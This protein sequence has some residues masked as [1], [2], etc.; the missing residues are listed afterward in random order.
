MENKVAPQHSADIME[1]KVESRHLGDIV[2]LVPE[3]FRDNR[4]VLMAT[5]RENAFKALG[6]PSQ[7]PLDLHSRSLK[8]VLRGLHF[9]WDPPVGKLMRVIQGTAFL[10]AVDLRKDSPTL[11]KWFGQVFTAAEKKQL[12][13]PA[14][15]ARG[16]C[17]LTDGV[18]IEYLTTA[19]Y[20]PR[21]ETGI[22]WNDPAIGIR[23]PIADPQLSDR[24]RN[25]QTL[26]EW[27]AR[28]ESDRFRMER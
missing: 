21:A 14:S 26:A 20:N 8:G 12:W 10:V 9:Q 25:A 22:R 17:A 3:V 11:G 24:D 19:L 1:F 5:Y 27:L 4:G 7:F 18:E 28:P 15:F 13:A 23:W 2:V 6:L 16:F